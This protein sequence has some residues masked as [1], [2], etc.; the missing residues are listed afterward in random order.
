MGR[1]QQR[2]PTGDLESLKDRL[3]NAAKWININGSTR[4]LVRRAIRACPRDVDVL[5]YCAESVKGTWFHYKVTGDRASWQNS[6]RLF[7]RALR[8]DPEHAWAWEGLAAILDVDARYEEAEHAARR[9]VRY[10]D[11]PCAKAILAR[12]LAQRGKSDEAR[13]IASELKETSSRDD[14]AWGVAREVLEGFWDSQE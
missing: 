4:R 10:G 14:F 13:K 9:A 3:W 1:R 12:V 6:Y 2:V 11:D 5:Y 7:H 8:A